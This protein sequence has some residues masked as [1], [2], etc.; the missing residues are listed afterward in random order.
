M[1]ALSLPQLSRKAAQAFCVMTSDQTTSSST[2]PDSTGRPS[3]LFLYAVASAR[4][5]AAKLSSEQIV[6]S[7]GESAPAQ[8][9]LGVAAATGE[10]AYHVSSATSAPAPDFRPVN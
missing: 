1:Q 7:V 8:E 3:N 5:S 10:A 9:K 2:L 4:S 6:D